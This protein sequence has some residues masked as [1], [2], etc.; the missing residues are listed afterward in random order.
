MLPILQN[1]FA[2]GI[3]M[4]GTNLRAAV[5]DHNGQIIASIRRPS[6]IAQAQ[7]GQTS[8]M[9]AVRDVAAEAAVDLGHVCGVGIGI[10]GWVDRVTG[11]LVFAPKM[12]NWQ[13]VFDLDQ[14]QGELGLCISVD[15]D[16]N[17][18]TLGEL[19][20]GAGRGT[21]NMV[22]V[23]L[24]TG[25]GCGIVIDGKLYAGHHGMSGEFGH[26]VVNDGSD[27]LCDCGMRGCLETQ[28]AGP[29]IARQGELAVANGQATLIS[30]LAGGQANKVTTAIVFAAAAQG[31]CVA[32]AIVERAGEV[33]GIGLANLISLFEPE[34]LI[35]GGGM[36]DVGELI[37]EPM[38]RTMKSH[39]YLLSMGYISVEL[40]HARLGDHAGMVGA[41]K[42]AFDAQGV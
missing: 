8:L 38:R 41:A 18:A 36:A 25:I 5:V 40:V 15:S 34:M 13:A 23:T 29:A 1:K 24:G 2:I 28:V 22:M 42:L 4:G 30:T 37:L 20:V 17:V 35:V 14:L 7:Q 12:V 16:P 26:I 11:R 9:Q 39:C 31:D 19:W 32:Y 33:L 6:P 27:Y 21:R 3:D 10:P